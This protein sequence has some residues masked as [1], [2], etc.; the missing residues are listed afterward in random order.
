MFLKE[1]IEV[2]NVVVEMTGRDIGDESKEKHITFDNK[3]DVVLD[4]KESNESEANMKE[5]FKQ[6]KSLPLIVENESFVR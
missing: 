4:R 3:I 6:S 5:F 1:S 2:R